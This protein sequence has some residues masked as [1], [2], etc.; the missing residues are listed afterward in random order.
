MTSHIFLALGLWRETVEANIAAIA[1]VDRMRGRSAPDCG[2]YETWL[3][4]AYLQLDQPDKARGT[5]TGCGTMATL[6][7][8][9]QPMMSMDPDNSRA[10]SFAN[11]RLRY[12]IDTANWKGEA[13]QARL[14]KN[15]GPGARLDFA[16]ADALRAIGLRD[17]NAASRAL[18]ELESVAKEVVDIET[19]RADPD[20]TYRVRPTI[21][22][23]EIQGLRPGRFVE[24]PWR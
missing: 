15:A 18:A 10:G 6:S 13:A 22:T 21:L 17:A 3:S 8:D 23:L 20:P 2:H 5:L 9:A 7:P 1:A 4:Y 24:R 12:L 14:P 11:M 19:R 16:F